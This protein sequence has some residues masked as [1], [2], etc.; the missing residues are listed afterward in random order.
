M[1]RFGKS[2]LCFVWHD[3]AL[4]GQGPRVP[5]AGVLLSLVLGA[6]A[7]ETSVAR[8]CQS[9]GCR[10]QDHFLWLSSLESCLGQGNG[11]LVP[12]SPQ[13]ATWPLSW[14]HPWSHY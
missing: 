3:T 11:C 13:R 5:G 4:P 6:R 1:T 8:C 2:Q 12:S 9:F 10:Y 14:L 7:L